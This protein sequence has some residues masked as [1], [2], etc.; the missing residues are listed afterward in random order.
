MSAALPNK[1]AFIGVGTMGSL[2]AGRLLD[3]GVDLAVYDIRPEAAEPLVQRGA[4]WADSAE[5]AVVRLRNSFGP[6]CPGLPKWSPCC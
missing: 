6:R 1:Q 3:A 4:R 5:A 2:M